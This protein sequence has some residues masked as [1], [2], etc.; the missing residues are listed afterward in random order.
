MVRFNEYARIS[1]PELWNKGEQFPI[2]YRLLAD[3]QI[4]LDELKW[5]RTRD[6][7]E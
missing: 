5:L 1:I 4:N 3:L 7:Q 2:R 6:V